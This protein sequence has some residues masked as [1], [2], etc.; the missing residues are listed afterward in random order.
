MAGNATV[1]GSGTSTVTLANANLSVQ[2][3]GF[4]DVNVVINKSL[5]KTIVNRTKNTGGVLTNAAGPLLGFPN[6][7]GSVVDVNETFNTNGNM[8]EQT[9]SGNNV[10]KEIKLADTTWNGTT[11]THT[12]QMCLWSDD[13]AALIHHIWDFNGVANHTFLRNMLYTTN[14]TDATTYYSTSQ[15]ATVNP[16]YTQNGSYT[17]AWHS[18]NGGLSLI[19]AQ[20]RSTAADRHFGGSDALNT[21]FQYARI[22][23][24]ANNGGPTYNTVAVVRGSTMMLVYDNGTSSANQSA[25]R[26]I[27]QKHWNTPPTVANGRLVL[28]TGTA[29]TDAT[30][31]SDLVSGYDRIRNCVNVIAS[32]NKIDVTIKAQSST[33]VYRNPKFI[34]NSYTASTKPQVS[35]D[36]TTLVEGTDYNVYVDTSAQKC[37]VIIYSSDATSTTGNNYVITS[38]TQVGQNLT[39]VANVAQVITKNAIEL[40]NVAQAIPQ[41]MTEKANVSAAL[42]QTLTVNGNIHV[43]VVKSVGVIYKVDIAVAASTPVTYK[44]K[45]TIP[46]TLTAKANVIQHIPQQLTEQANVLNR[47]TQTVGL[48]Y[49]VRVNVGLNLTEKVNANQAIPQTRIEFANILNTVAKTLS[50]K[51]NVRVDA[52]QTEAI[53]FA[54]KQPVTK[55]AAVSYHVLA[56]GKST[57]PLVYAVTVT[58][59]KTLPV[60]YNCLGSAKS[61]EAVIYAVTQSI[62]LTDPLIYKVLVTIPQVLTEK[63]NIPAAGT[64]GI[65]AQTLTAKANFFQDA[66]QSEAVTYKV[67]KAITISL[68]VNYGIQTSSIELDLPVHYNVLD[69]NTLHP[70]KGIDVFYNVKRTVP[71]TGGPFVLETSIQIEAAILHTVT[72]SLALNYIQHVYVT[73]KLWVE[74][75]ILA[76]PKK[77]VNVSY[78]YLTQTVQGLAII[79]AYRNSV[80]VGVGFNYKILTPITTTLPVGYGIIGHI[81]GNLKVRYGYLIPVTGNVYFRWKMLSSITRGSRIQYHVIGQAA[82]TLTVVN[83]TECHVRSTLAMQYEVDATVTKSVA[84]RY[85]LLFSTLK[86]VRLNWKMDASV[87]RNF[88]TVMTGHGQIGKELHL[89]LEMAGPQTK[90]LA[91]RYPVLLHCRESIPLSWTIRGLVTKTAAISYKTLERPKSTMAVSYKYRKTITKTVAVHYNAQKHTLK[92]LNVS[93]NTIVRIPV[94]QELDVIFR[95]LNT[96]APKA[97]P[98]QYKAKLVVT[99]SKAVAYHVLQ[100]VTKSVNVNYKMAEPSGSH[101]MPISYKVHTVATKTLHV[102]YKV[103]TPA[104]KSVGVRYPILHNL[105][106]NLTTKAYMY[107]GPIKTLH[108][109]Y[110]VLEI[111]GRVPFPIMWVYRTRA[112]K[113]VGISYHVLAHV[114]L[115][116]ANRYSVLFGLDEITVP[117]PINVS[118]DPAANLPPPQPRG[119]YI[120]EA[121]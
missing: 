59:K 22:T 75:T 111:A 119:V 42:P 99:K 113:S 110:A 7:S 19:P 24:D 48:I 37:Y 52:T 95:Y 20:W 83:S 4:G 92:S 40:A 13:N 58:V 85:P 90:T 51:A 73:K 77:G 108:V 6:T 27:W 67:K 86:S 38:L 53:I 80:N 16:S 15:R 61:T 96:M 104:T 100:R 70:W 115:T 81:T 121:V 107:G 32:S 60:T 23:D 98:I 2:C 3:A 39:E 103:D 120:E 33:V 43:N 30:G 35:K 50:E 9:A 10:F 5:N 116:L 93:Y 118:I 82:H 44:I 66:A 91:V 55:S 76:G 8:S 94:D 87:G 71:S 62:T 29:P 65:Q 101:K 45:A 89:T 56:P 88:N 17:D 28:N 97:L 14:D 68:V 78:A 1:T 31:N 26:S 21:V 57:L 84:V 72:R 102:I 36:G 11:G 47:V 12:I 106:Q 41:T 34:V 63:A 25:E 74:Y 49:A 114:T 105:G 117:Q 112:T 79:Y 64:T 109:S 69:D 18:T 54:I 46:Q